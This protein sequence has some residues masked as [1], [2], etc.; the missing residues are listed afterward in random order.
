MYSSECTQ[1]VE[2]TTYDYDSARCPTGH[3]SLPS[4]LLLLVVLGVFG[5]VTAALAI[6]LIAESILRPPRMTDGKALYLLRRLAP[7]DLGLPY[8]RLNISVR[9]QRSAKPLSLALWWAPR[10][11]DRAGAIGADRCAR[12]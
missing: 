5:L 1:G 12:F 9:D 10:N 4:L 3:S 7:D 2:V 8:E 6:L 11:G